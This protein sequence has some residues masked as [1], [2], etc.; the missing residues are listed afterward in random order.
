VVTSLLGGVLGRMNLIIPHDNVPL[1]D[2]RS[3]LS[4][5]LKSRRVY[6]MGAGMRRVVSES[7]RRHVVG[8]VR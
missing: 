8:V 5:F 3:T 7:W 4:A 2:C 6:G 1:L